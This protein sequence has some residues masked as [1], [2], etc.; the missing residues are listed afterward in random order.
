MAC[1]QEWIPDPRIH[2]DLTALS[3][4][5]CCFWHDRISSVSCSFVPSGLLLWSFALY[6]ISVSRHLNFCFSFLLPRP[7]RA[8]LLRRTRTSSPRVKRILVNSKRLNWRCGSSS[9]CLRWRSWSITIPAAIGRDVSP[10]RAGCT[11]LSTTSVSTPS[12]WAR[13]VSYESTSRVSI[14]SHD[15]FDAVHLLCELIFKLTGLFPLRNPWALSGSACKPVL[16]LTGTSVLFRLNA[17]VI[18]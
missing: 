18:F 5:F 16:A 4:C 6:I 10:G 12:C 9:E 17:W 2:Q 13:R 15:L 7:F 8:L 14:I 3:A 11:S 1:V